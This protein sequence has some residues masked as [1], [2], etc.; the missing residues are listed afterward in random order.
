MEEMIRTIKLVILFLLAL[1]NVRIRSAIEFMLNTQPKLPPLRLRSK[2]KR[3]PSPLPVFVK[4]FR[5][6]AS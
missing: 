3:K 5:Y 1:L 6:S 4:H 2:S